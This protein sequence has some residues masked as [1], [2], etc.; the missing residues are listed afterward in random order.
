MFTDP[1]PIDKNTDAKTR[2]T[3]LQSFD[4]CK[5]QTSALLGLSEVIPCSREI[6]VLFAE[7]ESGFAPIAMLGVPAT[8]NQAVQDE[9]WQFGYVPAV[10]R[11]Y[12]FLLM[13]TDD[14]GKTLTVCLERSSGLIS[15]EEG[16]PLYEEGE[17]SG[18]LQNAQ[19]LLQNLHQEQRKGQAFG[20]LLKE[21]ELLAP[22]SLT[23]TQN[24][25]KK[26]IPFEGLFMVD[27]KKLNELS[28]EDFL[29]L[30][31][32]GVLALIYA[33][34]FSLNAISRVLASKQDPQEEP[35]VQ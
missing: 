21:K 31:K 18:L 22:F 13:Q 27:E 26:Q 16:T 14:E 28:D 10:F 2:I 15:E 33:H 19:K 24:N 9:K 34:L 25:E 30:K 29:D 12:P 8:G 1:R 7:I 32:A 11:A 20:A 6:P 3:P 5:D 23:V 17:P 4:F 35:N